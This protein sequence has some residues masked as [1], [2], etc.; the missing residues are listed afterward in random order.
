MK[1]LLVAVLAL[2]AVGSPSSG[3]T[4]CADCVPLV[5]DHMPTTIVPDVAFN[6]A[7]IVARSKGGFTVRVPTRNGEVLYKVTPTVVTRVVFAR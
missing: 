3:H 7:Q 1:M 2:A 6:R 5:E 4:A